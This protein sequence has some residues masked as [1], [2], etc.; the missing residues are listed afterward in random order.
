MTCTLGQGT[1]Y[2]YV[3]MEVSGSGDGFREPR[4][5]QHIE[6]FLEEHLRHGGASREAESRDK[7]ATQ[8]KCAFLSAASPDRFQE[9]SY[10]RKNGNM[11][12]C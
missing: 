6:N 3:V 1:P 8:A 9:Y 4:N 10:G 5:P 11:Q 12:N 2:L 7:V